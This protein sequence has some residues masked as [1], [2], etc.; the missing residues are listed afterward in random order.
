VM[1]MPGR[2]NVREILADNVR[3]R[4]GKMLVTGTLFNPA[5]ETQ[6]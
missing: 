1:Y 2:A 4:R 3:H 5:Y 6:T